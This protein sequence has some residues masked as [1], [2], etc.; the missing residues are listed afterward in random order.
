MIIGRWQLVETLG[1]PETWSMLTAGTSPREWASYR[2]AIPTRLQPMIAAAHETGEPVDLMLPKSRNPWSQLRFRAVPVVWPGI[3]THGVKVWVGGDPDDE[4]GVAPFEVDGRT[5]AVRTMPA[6]LGPQFG[7]AP[8]QYV[9]AEIFRRIERFDRALEI[10]AALTRSEPG[11][12]WSGVATVHSAIGPRSLLVAARNGP[13]PRRFAWHGLTVDV[14]DSV[15]PQP[16]SFEATTLDLLR[17]SQP[18]LYLVILDTAQV[19]AVR[20]VT[21]PVPGL[22][23]RGVDDRTI[24]HPEDRARIVAAR[25][26]ILGGAARVGLTGL[27]LAAEPGGW[28]RADVEVSPLPGGADTGAAPAFVLAQLQVTAPV[29]DVLA[30]D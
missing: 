15:A 16:K 2:R 20:W 24:P 17:D 26:Q 12:R 19:R 13:H 29:S 9:G 3:R 22:R 8:A 11:S 6:G 5:R 1:T 18:G 14:T 27:R 28:L 7:S 21:E 25:G 10:V 4:P 30:P 23:W